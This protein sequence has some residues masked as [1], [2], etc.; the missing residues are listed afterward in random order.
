MAEDAAPNVASDIPQGEPKTTSHLHTVTAVAILMPPRTAHNKP[1]NSPAAEAPS[2]KQRP[3]K[4]GQSR[5]CRD[6][7]VLWLRPSVPE[8]DD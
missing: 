5:C 8:R 3:K 1:Q 7:R 6:D 2:R 4:Q